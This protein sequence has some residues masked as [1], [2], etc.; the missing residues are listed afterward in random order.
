MNKENKKRDDV[1]AM[2]F[3]AFLVAV[4]VALAVSSGK[5]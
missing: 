5:F 2:L 1:P 4:L 3:V